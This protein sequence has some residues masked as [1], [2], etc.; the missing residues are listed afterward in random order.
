[1][2]LP[3]PH[4]RFRQL[5]YP[6]SDCVEI[7]GLVRLAVLPNAGKCSLRCVRQG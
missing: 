4:E 2:W 1:M 5:I 3:H 6:H 7:Y